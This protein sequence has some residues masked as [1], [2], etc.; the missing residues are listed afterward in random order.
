MSPRSWLGQ[1]LAVA[2][3]YFVAGKAALLM[4]I[5]PGYATAVWPA[6]GIA[7]TAILIWGPRVCV[8]VLAGSFLVNIWT[9]FDASSGRALARSLAL[10]GAIAVGA[11]VQ[12]LAGAALI[13]RFVGFPTSLHR[14]WELGRFLLLG[15]PVSCLVNA[16]LGV[17]ALLLSGAIQAP[18]LPFSWWTW[19]VGD[20]IG[21]LLVAPLTLIRTAEPASVWRSRRG[22]VGIPLAICATLVVVLFVYASERDQHRIR[23][24]FKLRTDRLADAV[25]SDLTTYAETIHGLRSY[26]EAAPEI[27]RARF[28]L[29]VARALARHRG[30]RALGWNPLV[31]EE[32]RAAYE[33]T[34]RADG[35]VDFQLFELDARG[36]RVPA[37]PRA[38]HFPALFLEPEQQNRA[39]L[40]FDLASEATRFEAIA[41]ASRSGELVVTSRLNLVQDASVARERPAVLALLAVYDHRSADSADGTEHHLRG[42]VLGMFRVADMVATALAALDQ[43]GIDLQLLDV[44][45]P[46]RPTVLC[47]LRSGAPTELAL[48]GQLITETPLAFGDRQWLLRFSPSPEY[49]FLHRSWYAWALLALGLLFTSLL[50]AFLLVVT[51]RELAVRQ[52][53]EDKTAQLAQSEKRLRQQFAERERT[54]R[55]FRAL[56]ESAPDAMVIV[57]RHGQI[58]LVNAQTEMLFGYARGEM[59]QQTVEMFVPERFRRSHPELRAHY[60]S[61]P[62]LRPMGSGVELYGLRKD[63]SEFPIEIRLSPLETEEGLL[64]SSAIRDVSAT[65]EAERRLR[66]SLKEKEILLKEIHHRVK[67]NLQVISSLLNLQAR[68]TLDTGARALLAESQSRVQSIALVHEK[69]YQAKDLSYVDFDAYVR[70]LVTSLLHTQDSVGRRIECAIELGEVRLPID[71]AIPCGLIVNEL[72]TNAFKHAFPDGRPGTIRISLKRTNGARAA[73]TVSDDGVGLPALLD[74]SRTGSLGLE[75]VFT[76][77][78]QLEAAVQVR[79]ERGTIFR[80]EFPLA[81]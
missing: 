48:S 42:L 76:F 65:K 17:G 55:K 2:A 10:A 68:H 75:L 28:Q 79:S 1:V 45:Q 50:G 35:I 34:A 60:F 40:G 63:G 24:D 66:G 54:E 47:S 22:P 74:P 36:D 20:S 11:A 71:T 62:R 80:V 39:V 59:L 29:L 16:T 56:L 21:V 64:V 33:T 30:F 37:R 26:F 8:G 27:D 43:R 4:A 3:A 5:P 41:R 15:G 46:P 77:A 13:R 61:N 73:L 7:L 32:E 53:V 52:Q 49:A 70:T 14:E 81:S 19:W 51:G 67:N 23:M 72:V 18:Q 57:N 31:R 38:E 6:A 12:A 78:E 58:V 25:G 9:S 69:L 44:T